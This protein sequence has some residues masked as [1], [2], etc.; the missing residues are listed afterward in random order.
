MKVLPASVGRVSVKNVEVGRRRRGP[1]RWSRRVDRRAAAAGVVRVVRERLDGVRAGRRTGSAPGRRRAAAASRSRHAA[2]ASRPGEAPRTARGLSTSGARGWSFGCG[3]SSEQ[4]LHEAAGLGGGEGS[5]PCTA[6]STTVSRSSTAISRHGSDFGV[7]SDASASG[8]GRGDGR[9]QRPDRR[10]ADLPS[11]ACS[12]GARPAKNAAAASAS[13]NL[14]RTAITAD[15]AQ[16][17]VDLER[18]RRPRAS[19]LRGR[20]RTAAR[21]ARS[22]AGCVRGRGAV[23][24]VA[25]L[26]VAGVD[27]VA[28]AGAELPRGRE[29]PLRQRP[30]RGGGLV[31]A[32]PGRAP[33]WG[34]RRGAARRLARRRRGSMPGSGARR[35]PRRS[36][37]PRPRARRR[38]SPPRRAADHPSHRHRVKDRAARCRSVACPLSGGPARR[39]SARRSAPGSAAG[40]AKLRRANPAPA[41]PHAGAVGQRHARRAR[42]RTPPGGRRGRAR[43]SPARPGRCPRAAW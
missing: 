28:P 26:G 43:G 41:S 20:S 8:A 29:G 4:Q 5:R 18:V 1:R 14:P 37:R 17:V 22:P 16:R 10:A 30:G 24:G 12:V 42:G 35:A 25:L 2:M 40:V 19:P 15:A 21:S 33:R 38:R 6:S 3:R 9:D 27:R 34:S 13:A 39:P 36:T 7:R 32:S 11:Q 23:A 31:H